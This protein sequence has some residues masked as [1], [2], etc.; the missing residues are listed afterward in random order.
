MNA[1]ETGRDYCERR[2]KDTG[3]P[4]G[5]TDYGHAAWYCAENAKAYGEIGHHFTEVYNARTGWRVLP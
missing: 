3:R 1:R 4:Y 2:G 5:L